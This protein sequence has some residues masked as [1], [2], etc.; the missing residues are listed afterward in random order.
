MSIYRGQENFSLRSRGNMKNNFQV[1][2]EGAA[3]TQDT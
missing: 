1:K 2:V 3:A